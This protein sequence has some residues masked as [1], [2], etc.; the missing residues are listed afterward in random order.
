MTAL[1]FLIPLLALAAVKV[2]HL[3]KKDG[4]SGT[5]VSD[6]FQDRKGYIWIGTWEG[7]SRY[8]GYDFVNFTKKEASDINNFHNRVQ[9]IYQDR[10]DNIWVMMYND[11]LFRLNK[12]TESFE[13][14][15]DL[16]PEIG[17]CKMNRPLFT[18]GGD[19]WL[20]IEDKGILRVSTDSVTNEMTAK[21]HPLENVRINNLYEDSN[22]TVWLAS[23]GDLKILS[24]SLIKSKSLADG[25][26]PKV[27]AECK[28]KVI[29][30]TDDGRLL[31]YDYD[32]GRMEVVPAFKNESVTSMSSSPDGRTVY[33][34]TR[35]GSLYAYAL[36]G[37][38]ITKLFTKNGPVD[39]LY[40]DNSGLVWAMTADPGVTQYDP[41]DNVAR[42]FSQTVA[43]PD[44]DPET[45]VLERDGE[46]WICMNKGG[47][48]RYDR[49]KKTIDYFHHNPS[50]PAS[51]SNVVKRLLVTSKGELW[52]S[53]NRRGLDRVTN[54]G[55]KVREF[56]VPSRSGK[57]TANGVKAFYNKKDSSIWVGTKSG[58]ICI[59]DM[60]GVVKRHIDTDSEG[61]PLGKIYDIVRDNDDTYWIG[62]REDGLLSMKFRPDGSY[63]TRRYRHSYTDSNSL[64]SDE[65]QS[66]LVD[67][68]GNLWIA[69]Y[70]GGVNIGRPADGGMI[71]YSAGNRLSGYPIKDNARVRELAEDDKGNVWAATTDGLVRMRYDE[72]RQDVV[73]EVFRHKG[74]EVESIPGND[75]ICVYS[76]ADHT[77]W[78][79]TLGGGLSYY[80]GEGKFETFNTED[81]MPSNYVQSL[82]GDDKGNIWLST[83]ENIVSFNKSTR[84]FS[85]LTE[86][87]GIATAIFTE[88][89]AFFL[90]GGKL[91]FGTADGC[92]EV[93]AVSLNKRPDNGFNL[94]VTGVRIV[95]NSRREG[96]RKLVPYILEDNRVLLPEHDSEMELTVASLNY[97][98]QRRVRYQW[99]LDCDTLWQN[100]HD[101]HVTLS[102]L[103]PGTHILYVRAFLAGNPDSGDV[104]EV[105]IEVPRPFWQKWWFWVLVT[106]A[107]AIPAGSYIILRKRKLRKLAESVEEDSPKGKVVS[108]A[109]ESIV[110]DKDE[111]ELFMK[112]LLAWLEKNYSDP[113]MKVESMVAASGLGRTTFYNKLKA[114]VNASPVDFVIDFR[115]KKARML[116]KNSK[117]TISEIAYLTGYAD[118]HYFTRAYKSRYNETPTQYRAKLKSTEGQ[119][120]DDAKEAEPEPKKPRRQRK[121]KDISPPEIKDS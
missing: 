11:R 47:F 45:R 58:D 50:D 87:D 5:I 92:Y 41:A 18:A 116:M 105:A 62:T 94:Q 65:V 113:E 79:G 101:R 97:E 40:T 106:I 29:W 34:G 56:K 32:K 68:K 3:T 89:A 8:D 15:G 38:K 21:F 63:S 53:T 91:L 114:L 17:N 27:V 43:T 115:M 44:E 6:L 12:K 28:G 77:I 54:I 30:G 33:A 16:S 51:L 75:V 78:L 31:I 13:E 93:D 48:G 88:R 82:T 99:S 71:F 104:I 37:R 46:V 86:L 111:D 7:L 1:A 23:E 108:I 98:Q 39:K 59:Y 35:S 60:D 76:D 81:G 119:D 49:D 85:V 20:Q 14:L 107:V 103:S 61:K 83:E 24:S 42:Y 117:K 10:F 120:A 9:K 22:G 67:S 80:K 90:P 26:H 74:D 72:R 19:L 109:P 121:D 69:T 95:E 118:P 52:I 64:S 36:D 55:S 66:L 70:G 96:E 73:S 4:L 102:K 100:M 112:N 2:E 57:G 25:E 110:I 84:N